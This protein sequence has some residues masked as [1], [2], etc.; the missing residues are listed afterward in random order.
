MRANK[1][2]AYFQDFDIESFFD[3]EDIAYTKRGKNI[4]SQWIGL[5]ECPFCGIGG[6]HFGINLL[7]KGYSCWGCGEK[8]SAFKLVRTI[9]NCSKSEAARRI[10]E[11]SQK[12][13]DFKIRETGQEVLL[14]SGISPLD[15]DAKRYLLK[16]KFNPKQL[17]EEFKIQQLDFRSK[18]KTT[19]FRWRIFIPIVMYGKL[20]SYTGRDYTE[21]RDPR[22]QHPFLE[23]CIIPPSS[24]VYNIDTVKDKCIIFEGPTDVWRWG[25]ETVSIQGIEYTKEQLRFIV[26]K[27]IERCWI[28]FDA[29]KED[30]AEKLGIQLEPFIPEVNILSLKQGDPADMPTENALKTK[31]HLFYS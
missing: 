19:D 16:R 6:N 26:E 28:C 9:L 3:T 1:T 27:N 20:V 10:Q 22:Y 4:G 7:S 12:I 25:S 13:L 8:G 5:D 31:Y 17:V 11:F 21:K 14:P 29:G 18:L 15:A 23:A 2:S 24:A 30:K